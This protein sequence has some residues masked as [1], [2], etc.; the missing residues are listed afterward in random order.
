MKKLKI[1][2]NSLKFGEKKCNENFGISGFFI[3]KKI[4]DG[5]FDNFQA[6]INWHDRLIIFEQKILLIRF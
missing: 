4:L 6:N 1:R 3:A 5:Y 2:F